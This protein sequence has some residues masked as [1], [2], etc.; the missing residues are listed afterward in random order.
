MNLQEMVRFLMGL[1]EIGL[2]EKEIN[3]FLIYIAS[4]NDEY[5]PR[6]AVRQDEYSK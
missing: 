5:K 1:R 4:G 2:T 3:D 6:R